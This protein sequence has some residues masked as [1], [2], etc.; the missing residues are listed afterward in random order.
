MLNTAIA[1][2]SPAL[3]ALTGSLWMLMPMT[4]RLW[5]TAPGAATAVGALTGVLLMPFTALGVLLPLSLIGQGLLFD[6]VLWRSST[7]SPARLAL[8]AG[9]VGALIGVF[10]LPVISAEILTPAL[11]VAVIAIRIGSMVAFAA[12]SALLVRSLV[13]RGVRPVARRIPRTTR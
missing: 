4:A 5:S 1:T 3:Y 2:L 7:P 12:L 10:S 8:A 11:M 9:A 13:R 6:L